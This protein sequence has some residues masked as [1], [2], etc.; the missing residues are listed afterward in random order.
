MT[1]AKLSGMPEVQVEFM[2]GHGLD[3]MTQA[4]WQARPEELTQK[5][6]EHYHSLR[7]LKPKLDEA[8]VK[9]LETRVMKR[10]D[11]IDALVEN[12]KMK[13]EKIEFLTNEIESLSKN[14]EKLNAR[15]EHFTATMNMN[16]NEMDAL[17]EFIGKIR[18]TQSREAF[19][20]TAEDNKEVKELVK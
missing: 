3:D 5:Y 16:P 10:D 11:V 8:K 18:Q 15:W 1:V 17:T 7:V 20:I 19:Q 13:A 12:G 9:K 14:M 2:A 6:R 4:Y